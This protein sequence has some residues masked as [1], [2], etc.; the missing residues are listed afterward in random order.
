MIAVDLL[1]DRVLPF[2]EA[3]GVP[4]QRVLTDNGRE[5]CGRPP[6]KRLYESVEALQADLEPLSHPRLD[7]AP[8]PHRAP[9]DG[10]ASGGVVIRAQRHRPECPEIFR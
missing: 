1:R 6:R 9:Q 8:D 5:C 2:Y 3:Q 10:G 4:L 7:A